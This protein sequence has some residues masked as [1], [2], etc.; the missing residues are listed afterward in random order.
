[1]ELEHYPFLSEA[2]SRPEAVDTVRRSK[3]N[4]SFFVHSSRRSVPAL[5]QEEVEVG[6]KDPHLD[7]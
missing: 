2:I 5:I 4:E 3:R 6:R 7:L 1:M